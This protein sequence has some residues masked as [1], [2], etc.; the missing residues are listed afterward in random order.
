MPDHLHAILQMNNCDGTLSAI[1][2]AFKS[3]STREVHRRYACGPLWQ[4]GF[5]DRIV[6]NE[7]ELAAP[8]EYIE[9]NDIVHAVR[10]GIG[11]PPGE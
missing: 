2:Q 8:R 7:V 1:V 9:H 6:R 10:R 3:L 4:R 11:S 5:Y